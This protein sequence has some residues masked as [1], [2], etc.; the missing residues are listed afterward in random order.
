MCE[1]GCHQPLGQDAGKIRDT[2]FS[3]IGCA[4]PQLR[5]LWMNVYKMHAVKTMSPMPYLA[6]AVTHLQIHD[7][8]MLYQTN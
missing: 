7:R 6:K 5:K 2:I 8:K 3:S 4:V 1:K